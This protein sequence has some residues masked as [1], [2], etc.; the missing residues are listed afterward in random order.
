MKR[1]I[2]LPIFAA[3]SMLAACDTA[4]TNP[5]APD[6]PLFITH[7]VLDNDNHP[8]VVLVVIDV[9]DMPTWLCSG[10]LVAPTVVV[11]A[12]H[13]TGEPGEFSGIRVFAE[14]D[15]LHG[16]SNFPFGGVA[17]TAWHSHPLFS[18]AAFFLHDVGVIELSQAINLSADEY[19]QLPSV[20]QLDGLKPRRSNVFTAVG[21]GVQRIS[22]AP[23]VSHLVR[24]SAEPW[25]VQINTAV[26]G[27]FSLMLSNNAATG[28]TC[29]GDSGGPDYLGGSNVI[30]GVTSFGLNRECGGTGG[31][32]R[33]DRQDVIDFVS[34]YLP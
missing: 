21:Y 15:P 6:H 18:E 3:C 30:A 34:Q 24:M 10:T 1:H 4:P 17:A 27:N 22:P 29:L 8:A 14:A 11:T 28:G 7:G 25:L 31:V 26:T 16:S 32:F 5:L 19:G 9:D 20:N 12:G 33:L 23:G 2:L 13:C